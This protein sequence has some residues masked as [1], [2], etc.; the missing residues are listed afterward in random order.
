M[1]ENDR[2]YE[3]LER[4]GSENLT[5][6]E[7]LAIIIKTGTKRYNCVQIA[8]NILSSKDKNNF[9]TDLEYLSEMSITKLQ[10]FEGIGKIKAIEIKAVIELSKRISNSYTKNRLKITSPKDVY[11]IL[12]PYFIDKK[13]ECLKTIL[14]DKGNKIISIMT[15]AIGNN[16]KVE[17]GLKEIL[18]EPIKHMASSII[19]AHNHPSGNLNPSKQDIIFTQN[20]EEY[21]KIFNIKLLDHII[22]TKNGYT[23]FKQ[24]NII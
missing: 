20:I 8:Q 7:L 4:L 11:N 9:M 1:P 21:A 15:N 23:S 2:P 16:D 22:I 19:L 3:K 14:L 12:L 13:Q 18:S 5:N 6:S 17:I 10:E 24:I